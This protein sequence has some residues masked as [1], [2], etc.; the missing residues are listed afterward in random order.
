[1]FSEVHDSKAAMTCVAAFCAH[2]APYVSRCFFKM[3][4][5]KRIFL[6]ENFSLMDIRM[7]FLA[8]NFS[9]ELSLWLLLH[10]ISLLM[11]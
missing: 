9:T 6:A 3:M 5:S 8:E 2:H 10:G 7:I 11:C 4:I 1:M